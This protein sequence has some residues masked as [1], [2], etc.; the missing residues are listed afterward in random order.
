ML[1]RFSMECL[2]IFVLVAVVACLVER[3]CYFNGSGDTRR[4][5]FREGGSSWGRQ[6]RR[7]DRGGR[8]GLPKW[9]TDPEKMMSARLR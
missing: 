9:G 8:E 7:T 5:K 6:L 3:Q 4:C 1:I 2:L